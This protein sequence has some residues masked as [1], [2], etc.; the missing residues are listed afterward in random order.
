MK[1]FRSSDL[2]SI[3][4]DVEQAL[5]AVGQKHGII[6]NTGRITYGSFE[7]KMSLEAKIGATEEAANKNIWDQH[8][9]MLG[10]EK[11]DFGKIFKDGN[12]TWKIIGYSSSAKKYDVFVKNLENGKRY[13]YKAAAILKF[14]NSNGGKLIDY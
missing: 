9:I 4:N 5:K 13:G 10:L 12:K 6:F 2:D 14:K 7:F 11:S 8:C 1:V 3:R